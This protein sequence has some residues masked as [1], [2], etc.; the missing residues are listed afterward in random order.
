MP[1]Q[2]NRKSK[3]AGTAGLEPSGLDALTWG[4][5]QHRVSA[6]LVAQQL[7]MLQSAAQAQQSSEI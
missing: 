3:V 2:S 6:L 4:R 5:G 1:K 7:S